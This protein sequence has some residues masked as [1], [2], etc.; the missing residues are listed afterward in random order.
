M[1]GRP[2]SFNQKERARLFALRG[3][4]CYL[5]K[6]RIDGA[7]EAFDIEHEIPWEIS[8]DNSDNNLQLAHRRCHKEKTAKDAGDIAKAKRRHAKHFGYYP[9]PIGNAKIKSRGFPSTRSAVW[10]FPQSRKV[11]DDDF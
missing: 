8:R 2:A 4:Q 7:R 1:S 3:G 11:F 9:E 10:Q 5:C 6:G